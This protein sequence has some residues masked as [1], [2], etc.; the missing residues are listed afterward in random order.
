MY[1]SCYIHKHHFGCGFVVEK[2]ISHL[3]L[4]FRPVD[5]R[6]E[7]IRIK[8]PF[9]KIV[10]GDFITKIGCSVSMMTAPKWNETARFCLSEKHDIFFVNKGEK[11]I[12]RLS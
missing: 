3:I 11:I 12:E 4:S 9:F 2:G 5:K 8:A 6:Q 1:Y 7:I 10:R